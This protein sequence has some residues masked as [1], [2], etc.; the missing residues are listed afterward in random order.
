MSDTPDMFGDRP[1]MTR[2][3]FIEANPFGTIKIQ[4]ATEEP[5]DM[6]PEEYEDWVESSRGI[7]D[8]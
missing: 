6:T 8:D 4:V 7:W 1:K 2:E 3:E 5:R